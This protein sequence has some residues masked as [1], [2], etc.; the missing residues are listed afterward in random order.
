MASGTHSEII[1][2]VDSVPCAAFV[3]W[4]DTYLNRNAAT[5]AYNTG[6][7]LILALQTDGSGTV[8]QNSHVVI[9]TTGLAGGYLLDTGMTVDSAKLF[10]YCTLSTIAGVTIAS[11]ILGRVM[12]N[13]GSVR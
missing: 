13:L 11:S 9:F 3:T 1:N 10:L 2:V 4:Y 12:K 5:T 7:E 8:T 6:T